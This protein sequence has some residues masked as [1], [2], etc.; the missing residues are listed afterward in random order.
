MRPTSTVPAAPGAPGTRRR[1][2]RGALA[3]ASAALAVALVGAT[4]VGPAAAAATPPVP[5]LRVDSDR[6]GT[7]DLRA[8]VVADESG[9]L[10][11]TAVMLPNLDDDS[12]RCRTALGGKNPLRVDDAVLAG[13]SDAADRAVN[14]PYD[15][16]DLAPVHLRPVAGL[17]RGAT[18]A[19]RVSGGDAHVTVF[20]RTGS[21]GTSW[22]HLP[23]GSRLTAAQLAS[24]LQLGVEARDVR[25]STRGWD[26]TVTVAVDVLADG[27]R[28]TDEVRLRVAP[29]LTHHHLQRSEGV[30]VQAPGQDT[31]DRRFVAAVTAAAEAARVVGGVTTLATGGDRWVQDVVEPAYASMPT[32][33]GGVRSMRLLLR[34]DQD[35][36]GGRAVYGLRGRDVGVVWMGAGAGWETL[37]SMGN[38]ETVPPHR[39]PGGKDYPAGRIVM[40]QR[41]DARGRVTEAPSARVLDLLRAQ[42]RQDPLMLDTSFLA[43]GHVDEMFQFVPAPTP[44]GWAL[45]AASP[46]EGLDLLRQASAAGAGS[47]TVVDRW[48]EELTVDQAIGTGR[49]SLVRD[50]ERAAAII[51]ENVATIR[52]ATGLGADEVVTL[53]ALYGSLDGFAAAAATDVVGEE[54]WA[55]NQLAPLGVTAADVEGASQAA[56]VP[57]AVNGLLT[58]RRDV[59]VAQQFG[60]Q[61]DGRD[62][63]ADRVQAAYAS[64]GIRT[65]FVDDWHTYHVGLGEVHCGTNSLRDT[66]RRWW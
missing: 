48:D 34:S 59:L 18:G 2:A 44:R 32:A 25:R 3:V 15:A 14:G 63:F 17:P 10:A 29:L 42:G 13:C 50:N 12:G 28:S 65:T 66:K 55:G 22:Q 49:R 41:Y 54:A 60:V 39:A 52:A 24:G 11:A 62:V 16:L 57:G 5:D 46:R 27:R 6:D 31:S 20:L 45:V 61:V 58:G 23:S 37:D 51:D 26:G 38:L 36:E 64:L 21:S 8:G 7:V 35:R 19:L 43:V 9:E 1:G 33:G 53:P 4:G 56:F 47:S 30:L 40:G